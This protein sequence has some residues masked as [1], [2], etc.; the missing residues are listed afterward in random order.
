M[1]Q[2]VSECP[3]CHTSFSISEEQL[4]VADGM[5]RCGN[6]LHIYNARE[7]ISE[8]ANE[9]PTHLPDTTDEDDWLIDDN[10]VYEKDS[11][12]EPENSA[13]IFETNAPLFDD[14]AW[15]TGTS[16][17]GELEFSDELLN[18]DENNF[19][20]DALFKDFEELE[21]SQVKSSTEDWA[22]DLLKEEDENSP[23]NAAFQDILAQLD[24]NYKNIPAEQAS[25][26]AT[27]NEQ[28]QANIDNDF[29]LGAANPLGSQQSLHFKQESLWFNIVKKFGVVLLIATLAGQYI[30]YNFDKLSLNPTTRP[31]MAA[32]C[33]TGLCHLKDQRDLNKIRTTNLVVRNHPTMN[34]SLKVDLILSNRAQFKQ[35]FPKLTL[36]FKD[37]KGKI[38][39]G[40][41][42]SPKSYL[43][44][45][46]KN[47][48]LMPI[49]QAIHLEFE[50][51]DPGKDAINYEIIV[52]D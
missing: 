13:P 31:M 27:P 29:N 40:R 7:Q 51:V 22:E 26:S 21:K 25:M 8:A 34:D 49:N 32:L 24:T 37:L 44:G 10:F 47:Q 38:I 42:F 46:L 45:E 50:I 43:S 20:E 1:T 28:L 18:F 39:A 48:K 16:E 14:E 12:D 30:Y 36:Q 9:E 23:E 19:E 2:Y 15:N 11:E 35:Q 6:C 41:T 33:Q 52:S 3:N 5:V 17:S 4:E